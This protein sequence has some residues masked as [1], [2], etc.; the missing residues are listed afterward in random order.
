MLTVDLPSSPAGLVEGTPEC[1][2][3][4]RDYQRLV[5]RIYQKS[6]TNLTSVPTMYFAKHE[7]NDVFS[8]VKVWILE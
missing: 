5:D 4:L 2:R 1:A 3:V 8:M 6:S 7:D